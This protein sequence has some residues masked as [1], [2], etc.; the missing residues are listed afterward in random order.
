MTKAY[1]E[2]LRLKVIKKFQTTSSITHKEIAEMFDI[3]IATFR[4][5]LKLFKETGSITIKK[6]Q[7]TRPRK[8][9]YER[10]EE[11]VKLNPD[12]TLKEM[13]KVLGTKDM[14]YVMRKLGITNK[15]KTSDT[16]KEMK[17]REKNS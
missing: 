7:T 12:K 17:K 14:G 1:S 15:K 10:V 13:G 5:W 6:P 2:D 9:N 3:G 11:Y 16:L 8:V 4:R